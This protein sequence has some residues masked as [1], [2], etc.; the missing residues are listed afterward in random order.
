MGVET[1]AHIRC[2]CEALAPLRHAYLDSCVLEPE[3]I[4][5][6]RL[7]GSSGASV[8]LRGSRD[9]M[10]GTKGPSLRLRCIGAVRSRTQ[11]LN[12]QSNKL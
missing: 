12:N 8:N 10:W 9:L 2:E 11:M 3:D 6:F 5:E 1:S 4:K 7:G